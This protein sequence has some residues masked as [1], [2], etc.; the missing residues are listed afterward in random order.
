MLS[1]LCKNQ[2]DDFVNEHQWATLLSTNTD[3][4]PNTDAK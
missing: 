3:F 4:P 1:H 2:I